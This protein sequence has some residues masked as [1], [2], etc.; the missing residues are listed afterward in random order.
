MVR[1]CLPGRAPG[2]SGPRRRRRQSILLIT[3]IPEGNDE[4]GASASVPRGPQPRREQNAVRDLTARGSR[5]S[6]HSIEVTGDLNAFDCAV[7]L[8]SGLL[9]HGRR[10]CPNGAG[11][12]NCEEH[13]SDKGLTHVVSFS[14]LWGLL[15]GAWHAHDAPILG[16]RR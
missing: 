16:G 1:V 4:L 5:K 6:H 13:R 3:E 7:A 11:K 10:G 12:I 9:A 15:Y 2:G 14:N 8:I